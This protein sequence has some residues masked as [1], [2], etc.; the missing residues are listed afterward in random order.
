ML[1]PV[2]FIP[3]ENGTIIAKVPD[4]PGV[5]TVGADEREA[6]EMALDA[7]LTM[8]AY[9]VA[10]RKPVPMPSKAPGR[11]PYVELPPLVVAKV[12]IHN[13]MVEQDVTQ[14]ALAE[15][16]KTDPKAIRRLL[17]IDHKSQ[18][19]QLEEAL[20]VLGYVIHANVE[21]SPSLPAFRA[22]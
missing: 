9:L 15:R 21:R 22:A 8:V 1:Y 3:D 2:T 6:K 19:G 12:A 4:V 7:L 18:W 10:E 11:R 16:L 13:A 14:V 5:I 17:D 20:Q